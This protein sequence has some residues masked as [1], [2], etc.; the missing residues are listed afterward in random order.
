MM[1]RARFL[2]ALLLILTAMI[3]WPDLGRAE[4]SSAAALAGRV[5]SQE[6]GPMEGVLISA[7]K[8][9]STITVSVA[10]DP[11]G[12]YS[13]P[14]KRL[15]PGQYSLSI[16]AVGYEMD[17]AKVEVT[18]QKAATADLKL[19]KTQDLAA[20]LTNAEWLM[21]MPESDQKNSLIGCTMCHT[22]Q[23]ILYSTHDAAEFAQV[24][25][26]MTTYYIGSSPLAP[27]LV[28]AFANRTPDLGRYRKPADFLS[29]VNLSKVTKWEYPLKTLPR[30]KGRSTRM[31]VTE[32]ELPRKISQPHD[33][34]L[35]SD[36]MAW[37]MDFGALFVGKMDPKTG[38]V[39]EYPVP[40]LKP[41]QPRGG[42]EIQEDKSGN[43]WVGLQFQAGIAKFDKKTEK[44]QMYPLPKEENTDTAQISMVVPTY[45]YVDGKVWV[46]EAGTDQQIKRVD[47]ATGKF[48][49]AKMPQGHSSYGISADTQNNG[50]FM[51][52][53]SEYI[54]RVDAK[55]MSVKMYQTPTRDSGPRRGHADSQDRLWFAENRG[56]KV[57]MFDS[58]TEKIQEWP[59]PTPFSQPYDAVVD[60]NG[61]VWTGGMSNDRISRVN[62][63]TGAVTEYLMP[64]E[65]NVRRVFVD[66][67]T[68]PVTFW[69]GNDHHASIV[70]LEPLD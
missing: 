59:L 20:Q 9:G 19:R 39:T 40:L 24:I 26:R 10:S 31:I 49:A 11:Q 23:R 33:V 4:A 14:R 3:F 70:K 45:S 44:F 51:E 28:P 56:N 41:E 12:R 8:R 61:D 22:L 2:A 29:T 27:Q 54:G 18:A 21:S 34:I 58:R 57:G 55:T 15:E 37:Y 67:S 13:F 53:G 6:E 64:Q 32:Y 60:K 36:G 52:L 69:V 42:L 63:K 35:G 46:K 5:S 30:P 65:T 17:P 50:Y 43:I 25:H 66:N 68:T 7:K 62:S 47:V 48:E 1:T 16:R 38:Q